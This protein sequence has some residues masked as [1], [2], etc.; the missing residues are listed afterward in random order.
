MTSIIP[1]KYKVDARKTDYNV[2]AENN[3]IAEL[4]KRMASLWPLVKNFNMFEKSTVLRLLSVMRDYRNVDGFTI[5]RYDCNYLKLFSRNMKTV[6][7]LL[8]D[9]FRTLRGD[10]FIHGSIIDSFMTQKKSSGQWENVHFFPTEVTLYILGDRFQSQKPTD[11]VGYNISFDFNGKLFLPYS[12]QQHWCLIIFDFH[13]S[14]VMHYDPL[15]ISY[16]EERIG[17]VLTYLEQNRKINRS[18]PNLF[19]VKWNVVNSSGTFLTQK[20][21]FNCGSYVM[22]LMNFLAQKSSLQ[23]I[24]CF[25][26]NEFR[27]KVA[28][29]LVKYSWPLDQ[30]CLGCINIQNTKFD[31]QCGNCRRFVHSKCFEKFFADS[32]TSKICEKIKIQV[33]VSEKQDL[34]ENFD[35]IFGVNRRTFYGFPNPVNSNSCWLNSILQAILFLPVFNELFRWDFVR[36][37]PLLSLFKKF[38][39]LI[40]CNAGCDYVYGKLK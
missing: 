20:D 29:D 40:T 13:S 28:Y 22:F 2:I 1:G 30:T 39:D 3:E 8:N 37:S 31:H 18:K 25:E 17:R 16:S 11:F 15:N 19:T 14:T 33:Q 34:V 4:R 10:L 32:A 35:S 38:Q 26:P 27:V 5:A 36:R 12:Y 24:L 9:E 7:L 23:E 6:H 21:G